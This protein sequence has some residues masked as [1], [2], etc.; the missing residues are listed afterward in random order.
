MGAEVVGSQVR[1]V[2]F[3]AERVLLVLEDG[4]AL[5]AP[6]SWVGAT[7][8]GWDDARRASWVRTPDGR[9]VNWPDAGQTSEDGA[10]NV[11]VLEQDA[12]FE[13]ALDELRACDWDVS[14][15]APRTRSLVALWRLTAD[16]YN[17]GLLQFLG[18]WGTA[19][20]HAAL[21]A[22]AEIAATTTLLVLREFWELLGPIA[23]SD[24]VSTMDEVYAAV[25]A[26]DLSTGLD[27]LDERFWDAAE[28]LITLV[29]LA[30]GPARSATTGRGGHG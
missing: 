23:E 3:E 15:L 13:S 16:G 26:R 6:I 30:F 21:G 25:V 28:E 4:R 9:G 14:L 10:L 24:D 22:L 1:D 19:E 5:A 11:W 2:V 29:P 8:A 20:M 7:V 18:N 12:L 17:G 27:A